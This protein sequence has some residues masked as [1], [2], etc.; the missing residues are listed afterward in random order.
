MLDSLQLDATGSLQH[1]QVEGKAH[2]AM[3]AIALSGSAQQRGNNWQGTLDTL[4]L[5]VARGTDWTLQQPAR[6][7]Q[8]GSNWTLSQTCLCLLY[9][10]R[11]V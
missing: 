5:S 1:L 7:A 3:G 8:Q 10:S 9:T 6:F 4:R 2:N 11:C